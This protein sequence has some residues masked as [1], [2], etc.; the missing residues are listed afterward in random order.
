MSKR[1]KKQTECVEP[2]GYKTAK[3]GRLMFFCTCHSSLWN[4]KNKICKESRKLIQPSFGEGIANSMA[5]AGLDLFIPKGIPWL[6]KKSVEMGQNY[7]S[8]AMRNP[9]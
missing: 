9:K 7:T 2:S 4:N 6:G 5:D 8:E 3:N 1:K